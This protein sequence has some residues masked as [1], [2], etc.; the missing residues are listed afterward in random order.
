MNGGF[1]LAH[2]QAR[3]I[4]TFQRIWIGDADAGRARRRI[5]LSLHSRRRGVEQWRCVPT[6]RERPRSSPRSPVLDQG[7]DGQAIGCFDDD[8]RLNTG[9]GECLVHRAPCGVLGRQRDQRFAGEIFWFRLGN[10]ADPKDQGSPPWA[11]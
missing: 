9:L 10:G 7:R 3:D 11:T 8:A 2:N 4:K 6:S 5:G 1:E